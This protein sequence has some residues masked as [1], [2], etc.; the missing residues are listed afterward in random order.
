MNS[1]RTAVTSPHE[2]KP[3]VNLTNGKYMENNVVSS[4]V[5][6]VYIAP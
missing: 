2:A 5:E 1:L 4:I 3:T 6:W